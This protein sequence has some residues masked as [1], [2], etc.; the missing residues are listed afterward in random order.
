MALNNIQAVGASMFGWL[1]LTCLVSV[2]AAVPGKA[3]PT[4]VAEAEV[5]G[6][7]A[8]T[9]DDPFPLNAAGWGPEVGKGL[10]A[11]RWAENWTAM[12]LVGVAPMFKAMPVDSETFLTLSAE[13]R[14]RNDTYDNRQ[15][16]PGDDYQQR[17]LRGVLGADLR[18]NPNLRVYG[19]AGTGQV[20]G[21]RNTAGANFQ[22]CVS[23]Q[24]SFVEA[25][26]Y[27][28]AILLGAMMGRQ[29][30]ADGP[31]QLISLSD[32][33]NIHRTWNGVRLYAHGERVR[34]G[35][36]ELRSTRLKRGGFD[37]EVN[38]SERLRGLNASVVIAAD[39]QSS[40]YFDPF[41]IHSENP[42]FRYGSRVGLDDRD[43]IGVRVWGRR[44]D[45]RFDW[46]VAHQ[47][48]NYMNRD[49]DAWGIFAVQSLTLANDRWSPRLTAHIDMASG[50]GTYGT[51]SV[52]GFNQLYASSGYLGEGQFLS[53]S[54]LLMIAPGVSVS[55]T[56]AT[57]VAIEYGFARRL[58]ADDAAY[59]GGMRA[60]VGTQSAQGH[61]VGGLLRVVGTWAA[62][63]HLS[64][65]LNYEHLAAGDVL[66]R[67]RVPSGTYGSFG[68][69]FRY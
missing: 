31:R 5:A 9:P 27:V 17:L 50:G 23:L 10:L 62:T 47:S 30:F 64:L 2:Q 56:P 67:S 18:F 44:G 43:T 63:K 53:L 15:L 16:R 59:A 60:Y 39:K 45:W 35:A 13:V 46:T 48:G 4:L 36:Y 40:V 11:S 6:Q 26:G 28:G 49:I 19:E 42:S 37:E 61:E 32:G 1:V 20:D 66:Q 22:N 65:F 7:V 41:W 29:E 58:N 14:L 24:Q 51:G 38:N 68:A 8:P 3:S 21:H 34:V 52:Q 69:T 57:T 12:R 33:P 25:S 55:P 54:N